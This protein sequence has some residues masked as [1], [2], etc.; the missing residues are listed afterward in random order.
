MNV[1]SLCET[2]EPA[3]ILVSHAT[4]ALLE[5]ERLEIVVREAGERMLGKRERPV[6]VFEVA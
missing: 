5:G 3:Q 6:H 1:A 2:A 4:E